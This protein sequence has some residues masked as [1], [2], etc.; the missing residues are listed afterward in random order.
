VI[1][2]WMVHVLSRPGMYAESMG[3]LLAA[4]AAG[5]LTVVEGGAYALEDAAQAHRDLLARRT[6]GKLILTLR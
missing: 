5:E 6:T 1:G 3:D 4:V 2:F